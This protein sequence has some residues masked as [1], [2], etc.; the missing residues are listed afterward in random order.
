MV[1]SRG[2][3]GARRRRVLNVKRPAALALALAVCLQLVGMAG[4]SPAGATI[5]MSPPYADVISGPMWGGMAQG[6]PNSV[7]R[8]A[9]LDAVQYLG[10]MG[11]HSFDDYNNTPIS[12]AMAGGYGRSDAVWIAV[13][14]GG[15][16][17]ITIENKAT[18]VDPGLSGAPGVAAL[19][20]DPGVSVSPNYK[21][22]GTVSMWGL[23]SGGYSGMK[24]MVFF[25][26]DTGSDSAGDTYRYHGNLL[27]EA[28][29]DLG[30]HSAIG[31]TDEIQ[32][33][34]ATDW[35]DGFMLSFANGSSISTASNSAYNRVWWDYFPMSVGG[36]NWGF[37]GTALWGDTTITL[38]PAG[39]SS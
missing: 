20:A 8:G 27:K 31:F 21:V 33:P 11:Y 22:G 6:F 5:I 16:G 25:G 28:V 37:D 1:H 34:Q 14:H 2:H 29:G 7:S 10:G 17:Q 19:I 12:Y 3:S 15:P 9:S 23:A 18:G 24:V 36:N 30:V 4:A 39:Y 13:G 35:M 38:K 26:C 32:F